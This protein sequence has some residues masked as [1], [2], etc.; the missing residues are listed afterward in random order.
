MPR[1]KPAGLENLPQCTTDFVELLIKK[2]RYRK[3]VRAEVMTELT[4]HFEDAL[5][6]CKTDEQ[7]EQKARQLINDFGDVKLLAILL[8]RAK[9]R[10]RPLWRT[11]AARTFQTIGVLILCFIFYCVYISLGRPT[12]RINYAQELTR[13]TRP[14]ADD[15]LNA[16]PLYQKAAS[17]YQEPPRIEQQDPA[18]EVDLLSAV[19]GKDWP[20]NFTP[21]ELAAMRRWLSD[22][23]QALE[24]FKQASSTPHC[25]WER[26]A[27]DDNLL[28]IL[29]PELSKIR[30]L[31]KLSVWQAKLRAYDSDFQGAFDDLLACYKTGRHYKGPRLL[32]EQLVGIA[33]QAIST[34][35][36]F[37][38]LAHRQCETQL[39]KDFQ[40][41]LEHCVAED[42]YNIDYQTE[43]FFALD[44]LQR[45]YTDN[46]KGSGRMIPGRVQL[47]LGAIGQ[48]P[49]PPAAYARSLLVA[50]ASAD[51]DNMQREFD[52]LYRTG[53]QYAKMTP[54]QLRQKID[55]ETEFENWPA[56]KKARFWPVQLLAPALIKA[57]EVAH[58]SKAEIEALITTVAILTY[59]ND[60]ATLPASLQELLDSGYIRQLPMDPYCDRPLVYKKTDA[61]FTLYS[62][63]A[64]FHDDGGKQ[65]GR[66]GDGDGDRV[67]WPV[68]T[69]EH[70][71][72]RIQEQ[73]KAGVRLLAR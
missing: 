68:E 3:K 35:S 27:P 36:S 67:F 44:F 70:K 32:I 65:L 46:G 30:N 61:G 9:K 10:C 72:K 2:M 16:A 18:Q 51:R 42:T 34:Q 1:T 13:V 55:P 17:A 47:Y 49:D 4:A 12:I 48:S 62:I 45:C 60:K 71:Q 11:I 58:R 26:R 24:L 6:D 7:K 31:S 40:G 21:A 63:G 43:R 50:L 37:T 29:M 38:I 5:R 15:A 53:E 64:D 54:W 20:G 52:K 59:K 22:N 73:N 57:A 19:Q 14:S 66:W 69:C 41:K 33:I 25:W 39:L 28:T 56:L 23:A 8:R